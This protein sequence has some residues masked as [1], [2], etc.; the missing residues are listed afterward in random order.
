MTIEVIISD[1]IG[2]TSVE[3]E[4]KSGREAV[5]RAALGFV[6]KAEREG[7]SNAGYTVDFDDPEV[8]SR[9]AL[10]F[11][12]LEDSEGVSDPTFFESII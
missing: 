7:F 6:L 11:L 3:I 2:T 9:A 10:Y 1:D 5:Y 12:E 4:A 8:G